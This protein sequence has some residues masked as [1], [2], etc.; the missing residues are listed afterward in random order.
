MRDNKST[1]FHPSPFLT[2]R[3]IILYFFCYTLLWLLIAGIAFSPFRAEKISL[4]WKIDGIPQYMIWLQYTGKYIRGLLKQIPRGIITFPMYDFNIGMGNDIRSFFKTEPIGFLGIFLR[5]GTKGT[6]TLYAQLFGLRVYLIGIAFSCYGLYMRKDYRAVL[7]GALTYT[8]SSY[9]YYQVE[10]HPQFVLAAVMLPLLLIGLEQIIRRKSCLL[11]A[12]LVALS[13]MGSYYFLYMNTLIMG[14]YALVRFTDIYDTHRIRE[15]FQMLARIIAAYL[16]GCGMSL[17]FIMPTIAGFFQ[18]ARSS[19]GTGAKAVGSFLSY[20]KYRLLTEY[21]SLIAPVR[22]GESLTTISVCAFVIPAL[23]LLFMKRDRDKRSLKIGIIIGIVFLMVPLFGYIFSGFS[24]VNNRWSFAFVFLMAVTVMTEFVHMPD[25]TL[26]QYLVM[27]AAAGAYGIFGYLRWPGKLAFQAAFVI[28]VITVVLIG[29][30]RIT[31]IRKSQAAAVILLFVIGLSV[32]YN[33]YFMNAKDLGNLVSQFQD[34][35]TVDDYFT[36]S[37]YKLLRHIDDDSFYRIDTDMMFNNYNNVAVALGYNGISLYNSTIGSGIISYFKESE[38]IGISAVNRTL[39]LDNRSEQEALACVKYYITFK[40]SPRT[41]PYGFV[42]DEDISSH[43][44]LYDVYRNEYPLPI[45]YTYDNVTSRSE[46]ESASAIEKQNLQFNTAV[47]DDEDMEYFHSL[48]GEETGNSGITRGRVTI[49]GI[50]AGI[51]QEGDSYI[52]DKDQTQDWHPES[53]D[54]TETQTPKIHFSASSKANCEVYLH[55]Q[56]ITTS[57][58]SRSDIYVYTED[59]KKRALF[60]SDVDTYSL[61]MD[62]F[63][64]NLG[65]YDKEEEIQGSIGFSHSGDYRFGNIEIIYVPM[66]HYGEQIRELKEESLENIVMETNTISGQVNSSREHLMAFSIPYHAGWSAY[67][68]GQRVP[69]YRVNTLYMGMHI[70]DG[71]HEITLRYQSPG[72]GIGVAISTVFIM[73]YLILLLR[74]IRSVKRDKR[75]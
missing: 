61:N 35:E 17:L 38:S 3:R 6:S 49:T 10:R 8:F 46:Y 73:L 22:Q 24:T 44:Q 27:I 14:C 68:D 37:R 28:L 74:W 63:L 31:P 9:T 66:D 32:T 64:V 47:I 69:L 39:F 51:T 15:F 72:I 2:P 58:K 12:F 18:S 29:I 75:N 50:D 56:D 36:S 71:F 4:V 57:R 45:G 67:L 41:V 7:A 30:I 55:F 59:I 26:P 20:G 62:D 25:I 48:N 19:G 1:S 53:D 60:R 5:N 21:M 23:I 54:Q 40:D 13:L 43:S 11:F 65:Y 16:F 42:L 33:G 34:E 52:Y 70:P